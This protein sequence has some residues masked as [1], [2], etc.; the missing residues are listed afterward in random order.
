MAG[1]AK[2][3]KEVDWARLYRSLSAPLCD[4][5]CGK[6]CAPLHE[7][8][9]ACCSH[10]RQEPVLFTQELRWLREQTD[11]WKKRRVRTPEHRQQD[12]EI[13][14]YIIYAHCKGINHCRRPFRSL[15]CR[16]FPLEPYFDELDRLVGLTWM[17]RAQNCCPLIEHP[18]VR[19]NPRYVKQALAVWRTL[20]DAYPREVE[21]Y[22]EE[23]RKLRRRFKRQRRT[24]KLFTERD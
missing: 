21:C 10:E 16:F 5:D 22:I 20:M 12:Q 2:N 11:L 9:P 8:V 18:T 4:I 13:E 17:Y 3:Y 14:D 1:V 15:T 19:I 7:G 6:L 24:I 23:S